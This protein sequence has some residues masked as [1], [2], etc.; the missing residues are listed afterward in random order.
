MTTPTIGYPAPDQV[1]YR[2]AQILA[3]IHR[4]EEYTRL[5]DTCRQYNSD[6]TC[7]TGTV[8]INRF[9][10]DTDAEPLIEEALRALALKASMYELTG[11]EAAA[12]IGI[13]L[14]VDEVVHAVLAQRGLLDRMTT[15]TGIK[16]VHMTDLENEATPYLTD[17]FASACYMAAFDAQPPERYWLDAAESA[18][19][20]KILKVRLD[21]IGLYDMGRRHG[22]SF[23][24][25]PEPLAR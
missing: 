12:E 6:W 24:E 25:I 10:L 13:P 17:G 1:G 3:A 20:T 9:D 22:I 15:R 19:R 11:S 21:S 16:F 18:R 2:A 5:V 4:D 23:D 14:P 7:Q 8:T